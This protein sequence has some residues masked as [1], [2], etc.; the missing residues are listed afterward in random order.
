MAKAIR[1]NQEFFDLLAGDVFARLYTHFPEPIDIYTSGIWYN[2]EFEKSQ[3]FDDDPDRVMKLYA[4]TVQWLAEEGFLRFGQATG[5]P[6]E[7]DEGFLNC[8]LTSKGL[9][10]LRK[11]PDSLTGPG[12]TL[13][14]K[15][16]AVAKDIGSDTAKATMKQLVGAALGWIVRSVAGI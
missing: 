13:G 9:A 6:S 3:L 15:I 5:D 12:E 2:D 14:D 16:E 7:G 8:V 10:A 11:T 4:H 1:A